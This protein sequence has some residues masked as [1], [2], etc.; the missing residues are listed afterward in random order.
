[1]T[2]A[3]PLRAST[4]GLVMF[5]SLFRGG[6]SD[7]RLGRFE[8]SNVSEADAQIYFVRRRGR[9]LNEGMAPFQLPALAPGE[10]GIH[11][12]EPAERI[13]GVWALLG[14]IERDLAFA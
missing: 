10:I 1:M 11:C 8:Y 13:D 14:Q 12:A 9:L 3:S 4:S 6:R 2:P 5:G 7:L